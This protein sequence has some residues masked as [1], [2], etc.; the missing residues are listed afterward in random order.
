MPEDHLD[1]DAY[2]ARI[3]YAGPTAPT[4]ETLRALQFHHVRHIAFETL[5][6]LTGEGVRLDLPSLA[7]KIV[8]GG[9]GGYCFELNLLF[10]ALLRA[11]G[12]EVRPL[13]GRVTM[14]GPEHAMTART[15]VLLLVTLD[16]VPYTVDVGFGGMTPTGPLRLDTEAEQATP[17]EPYRL[18]QKDGS[19]TLRAS[20]GG[21][22]RHYYLFDLAAPADIDFEVGNWYVSTHPA[23]P[24][25]GRLIAAR[26]EPGLRYTLRGGEYAIHRPGAPSER[27]RLDDPDAV[28]ALLRETFRIAVPEHPGLRSA[29][30]TALAEPPLPGP[31]GAP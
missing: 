22:W 29:L 31:A 21:S 17:H 14:H 25:R 16:G 26:V 2:L 23:S 15:H 3:G 9:R 28:L 10:L 5:A 1:I 13:T 18:T 20:V 19:Y 8:A 24:F 12:F 4:L 11:L 6:M 27:R 30:A 7:L